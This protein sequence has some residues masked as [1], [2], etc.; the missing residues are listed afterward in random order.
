MGQD[1]P[2][3][4]APASLPRVCLPRVR[5]RVLAPLR[6]SPWARQEARGS[7]GAGARGSCVLCALTPRSRVFGTA[8]P[9]HHGLGTEEKLCAWVLG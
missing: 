7:G 4:L 8:W 1:C 6:P 5:S 9:T 2:A 3:A